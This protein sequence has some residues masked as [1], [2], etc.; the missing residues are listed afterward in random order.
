MTAPARLEA[1]YDGSVQEII[2]ARP[3][4]NI[5]D[6]ELIRCIK[7]HLDHISKLSGVRLLVFKAEGKHFSFGASVAEHLPAQVDLML[8]E[9]HD[10][11]SKIESLYLPTAAVVQGQCLGGA[12]ELV[13]WCG[14]IFA[15]ETTQIGFPEIKLA[16]YPPVAA[17]ALRWRTSGSA[18]VRLTITGESLKAHEAARIGLIDHVSSDPGE[19]LH[20]WYE[21]H[22]ASSSAVALSAAWRASRKPLERYLSE[23][24]KF[25]EDLYL[26]HLMKHSD[27][28]EGLTAF[29]ERRTPVWSIS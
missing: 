20:A 5:L 21:Q 14:M 23:D 7:G 3:P 28:M 2:L 12:A 8:P 18:A 9:F 15:D 6:R 19:A 29:M 10:L 4:A 25:A 26:N 17:A 22:L 24:L 11:F 13:M 1:L 16:V 27:P